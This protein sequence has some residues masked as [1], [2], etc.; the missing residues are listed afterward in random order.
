MSDDQFIQHY[1]RKSGNKHNESNDSL[2]HKSILDNDKSSKR[3]L[4]TRVS[5]ADNV[6]GS[7]LYN[8]YK[9]FKAQQKCKKVK[10]KSI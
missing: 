2:L 7:S 6:K 1:L 10:A 4:V 9:S 8:K 5:L 3:L